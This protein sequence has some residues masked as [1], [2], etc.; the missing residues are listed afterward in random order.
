VAHS[1]LRLPFADEK[2]SF[3][4]SNIVLQHMPRR[5]SEPY[6]RDF[7]RVLAPGGVLVFGVQDSFAAPDISSRMIRARHILRIRS[8]IEDVLGLGPRHMQMHCLPE[9]AVRRALGSAR[10]AD[11]QFTNTAAKDFN[12]KLVYLPQAPTFG[13][14][15]KQYCVV[16]EP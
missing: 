7:V 13:Y 14:V 5:F 11:I 10:V 4:Y 9:R 12:G 16:K 8:R 6:L 3:I 15:G 1:D 2:F